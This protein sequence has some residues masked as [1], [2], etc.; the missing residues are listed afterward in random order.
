M[1]D[2]KFKR[3][4]GDKAIPDSVLTTINNL[5]KGAFGVF[6]VV[7]AWNAAVTISNKIEDLTAKAVSKVV[8][9]DPQSVARAHEN[10]SSAADSAPAWMPM[11][12]SNLHLSAPYNMISGM[13]HVMEAADKASAVLMAHR[14]EAAIL[15]LAGAAAVVT[16]DWYMSKRN[17]NKPIPGPVMKNS[18]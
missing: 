2:S 4:L 6:G 12:V 16:T 11:T 5:G 1:F 14:S 9:G 10:I 17:K 7:S 8:T 3:T 18:L 13:Y 15:M